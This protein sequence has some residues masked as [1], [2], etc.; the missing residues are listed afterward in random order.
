MTSLNVNGSAVFVV[1][2]FPEF[3]GVVNGNNNT[4]L[5]IHGN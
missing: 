4:L 1:F 3:R 5:K 2:S